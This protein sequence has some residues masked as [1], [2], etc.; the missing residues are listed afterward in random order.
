MGPADA[1]RNT[2]V[3]TTYGR[4]NKSRTGDGHSINPKT[5]NRNNRKSLPKSPCPSIA[6]PVLFCFS[7][8]IFRQTLSVPAFVLRHLK[9]AQHLFGRLA[10]ISSFDD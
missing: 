7:P 2:V 8:H 5:K 4:I 9:G 10:V 1:A 6:V 3:P